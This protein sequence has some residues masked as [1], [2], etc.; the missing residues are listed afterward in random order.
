[1]QKKPKTSTTVPLLIIVAIF[2]AAYAGLYF[3]Y[4][5]SK[6]NTTGR[7]TKTNTNLA[8]AGQAAGASQGAQPPTMLGSPTASVTVEEFADFQCPACAGTFSLFKQ[9]QQAY[10]NRIKFVFRNFPLQMHDKAYEAAV[11]AEAAGLQGPDKFWAM[12]DLLYT[13]QKEW[14]GSDLNYRQLFADYAARV[15]LD[16]DKFRLDAAGLAAKTRVDADL[17]RGRALNVSSTP[18]VLINGQPV[19]YPEM[20]LSSMKRLIDA[21]LER[22]R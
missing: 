18:T 1:M 21:E 16:V 9:I 10:G 3:F 6:G 15:G 8:A 4:N 5:S 12:H 19:S 20:N 2:I 22:A 13:N 14:S 7:T 11:A 17:R